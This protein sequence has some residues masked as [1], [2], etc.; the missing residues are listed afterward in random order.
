MFG[1]FPGTAQS[2][3]YK[4]RDI[5][6]ERPT[7]NQR[8]VMIGLIDLYSVL[9]YYIIILLSKKLIQVA[10]FYHELYQVVLLQRLGGSSP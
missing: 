2:S 3:G 4:H 7:L 1:Q 10:I 5:F 8:P 6:V 9:F